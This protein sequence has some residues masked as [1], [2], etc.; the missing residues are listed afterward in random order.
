MSPGTG[1]DF[2][3]LPP[4]NATGNWVKVVQRL[5]VRLELDESDYDRPLLFSGLSVT[6]RVIPDIAAPGDIRSTWGWRR[7]QTND[8]RVSR[9]VPGP[10]ASAPSRSRL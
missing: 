5:P 8:H 9:R 6:V 4:E 3:V 1:S 7:R 2:A 10:L